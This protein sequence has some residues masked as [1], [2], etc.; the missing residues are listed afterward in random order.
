M[1]TVTLDALR[2][3]LALPAGFAP[4]GVAFA[5]IHCPRYGRTGEGRART[6]PNRAFTEG[7]PDD[8]RLPIGRRRWSGIVHSTGAVIEAGRGARGAPGARA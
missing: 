5:L 8:A 6:L 4:R 1:V 7:E 3:P 2:A